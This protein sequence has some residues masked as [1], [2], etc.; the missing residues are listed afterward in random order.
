[1]VDVTETSSFTFAF[2]WAAA[3]SFSPST[4][5]PEGWHL[6]LQPLQPLPQW[7]K[8]GIASTWCR[9]RRWIW[10]NQ[11]DL[12]G[13]NQRRT[14]CQ[15]NFFTCKQEHLVVIIFCSRSW[16][17][18]PPPTHTAVTGRKTT[19]SGCSCFRSL[20]PLLPSDASP[21]VAQPSEMTTCNS[22]KHQ[23]LHFVVMFSLFFLL[24]S[25]GCFHI[26]LLMFLRSCCPDWVLLCLIIHLPISEFESKP[27]S[28]VPD[29]VWTFSGFWTVDFLQH[30]CATFV[31]VSE[32][33]V[34]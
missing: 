11:F 13:Q 8:V 20:P 32:L 33:G 5:L 4:R 25:A 17:T 3:V 30:I 19:V 22:R 23:S 31:H 29:S 10:G 9:P 34:K 27:L 18:T 7:S 14:R 16:A 12:M 26:W 6:P 28:C 2:I 21:W 1:M 24:C 15:V